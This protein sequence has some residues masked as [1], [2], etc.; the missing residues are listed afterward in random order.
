MCNINRNLCKIRRIA[1]RLAFLVATVCLV[2]QAAAG[3]QVTDVR[4]GVYPSKTRVVL[5]VSASV[6]FR[7]FT[8]PKPYRVVIDMSE[9]TW[10]PRMR[11]PPRG[12]LITG[13]RFGLF[14]PG[15][16]RVVL[17]SAGPVKITKAFMVKPAPGRPYRVVLD[18]SRDSETAFMTAYK[19]S[20]ERVGPRV[21]RPPPPRPP[22]V[23]SSSKK[24][25]KAVIMIDPG[26]G[27]VDPGAISRS[28]VWEKHIVLAFSKELR[29]Q[30]LATGKFDVRMTRN[31]DVFIRL[32][33]RIARAKHVGADLFLSIHA[34]S[35]RN[36]KVRGASVYTLS[37]RA[38][39]KEADELAQKENKSDLIAGVDLEYQSN[40]VV[41]ILI[42]LAQ[43]ETMNESA[44]FARKLVT[45]LAKVRRM[46]RNTHRFA[47]FAVLKAPDIPS[48]LIELGY[49]SNRTDERMLRDA[50]QRR[51]M[52][53]AMTRAIRLY[54]DRQ[55]ALNKP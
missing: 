30:L 5:D 10:L 44:V 48:V 8:L 53:T 15:L 21:K 36:R 6:D 40:D 50:K 3:P 31:R 41:N 27:G 42:D 46:L 52:A 54:F 17:D 33:E 12:G 25:E 38:S 14:K 18:I 13:M 35:I 47:G 51:R 22:Q 9:V 45:E 28:G 26:H 20:G 55:Q 32:R 19:Q 23:K 2:Q 39:D 16:S 11:N 29:R 37:E 34:D 1:A 4:I 49:L 43:R 24:D 7:T